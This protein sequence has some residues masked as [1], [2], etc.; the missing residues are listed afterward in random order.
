M[1]LTGYFKAFLENTVN[2][3]QARLDQLDQRV[4]AI[5]KVLEDD[6]E[7][8]ERVQEHIPQ[9][10]WAHKTI[11]KPLNNHEFD[12][13]ILLRLDEVP[14]WTEQQYLREVRAA[15]KR[16]TT[17]K[18]MVRKKNRCVRVGYAN[19]CHVDVVP[20]VHLADGRQV[21]VNYA[22]EKFEDTNPEG[23]TAWMK[24]RDTLAHGNLRKVLRL[25]K[26]LRD[27][28]QTFSVPSVILTTI[29][30]E[31]VTAWEADERYVDVPT[32]L[33]NMLADLDSWLQLHPTMPL[34][35]DP[36]CPGTSFNHRWDQKQYENFRNKVTQYSTWVTE[37]YDET[38]KNKSITA[39][40]RVFGSDFK[41][42]VA[43]AA[44]AS[45]APAVT[46][47]AVL[48][49]RAPKEEYIEDRYP[50]ASTGYTVRVTATVLKKDGFR[51]GPLRG[52]RS[53]GK[54]RTLK[55][56]AATDVPR[57]FD[58]YWKIRNT[59]S[60]AGQNLRGELIRDGGY[61]TR[62]ETTQYKGR[63]YVEAYV[64]KNGKVVARDRHDVIID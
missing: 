11:L 26:Y 48:L 12:A 39:W 9:G 33:K 43:T 34:L 14:E 3:N 52:F 58:L 61:L 36:S 25:L 45:A 44:T 7:L 35:E 15:L 64:V 10:S 59:G 51:A 23:F 4:A 40:Q 42:P 5:V 54:Q 57:P 19:D 22:E 24:E 47:A 27:Y 50:P 29:L 62:T 6:T 32:A 28:K 13:D 49:P 17:Y 16:S 30:G 21:I 37:A 31:R 8:G 63:H 41:A 1:K 18:D 56:D 20:H 38:D 60:E 53:I 2:L 55:F 46:E